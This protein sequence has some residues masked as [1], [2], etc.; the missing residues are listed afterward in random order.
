MADDIQA[1][2]NHLGIEWA[3]ILGYSLG[4][5]VALQTA[6][7]YP[8]MVRKLVVIS[9]PVRR[10]GWYPEVL[11]NMAL[12]G[13]GTAKFM[14][15]SP[16]YQFYPT[17]DWAVLFTKLGNLARLDYDW[18]KDVAAIR[19]P[20]MIVFADADAVRTAHVMEFFALL[21]GGRR[22]ARSGRFREANGVARHSAGYDALYHS[23]VPGAGCHRYDVPRSAHFKG[24]VT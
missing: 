16:L 21:G 3:D 10:D 6:I 4:A 18:S 9:A 14:E 8:D 1:L 23:L 20:V 15:Q 11:E 19:S 13:P 24:R 17:T 7:R 22:D 5:G 2:M 12:M